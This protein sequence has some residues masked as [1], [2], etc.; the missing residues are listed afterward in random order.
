MARRRSRLNLRAMPVTD[1]LP[2]IYGAALAAAGSVAAAQDVTERVLVGAPP[3]ASRRDLVIE[4]VR[5]AVRTVPAPVFAGL[6]PADREA[7]ALVRLAALTVDEVADVT[8][9]EPA[10]VKRR[11]ASALRSVAGLPQPAGGERRSFRA[12]AHA[13]LLQHVPDVRLHRRL[14]DHESLGDLAVP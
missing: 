5:L 11:L 6:R 4:A 3:E 13:K 8:G 12:I 14:G 9:D 2:W 10:V 1:D 7:L